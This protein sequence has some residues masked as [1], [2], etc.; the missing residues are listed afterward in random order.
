MVC[1]FSVLTH[2]PHEQ[3][4]LY[5]REARRV[6]EPGGA[7]VFS[8]LEFRIPDHW[9]LFEPRL[10]DAGGDPPLVM[11]LGRDGIEA[12]AGRLGLEVA[13]MIDGNV[14]H[15]PIP[16]PLT[17]DDGTTVA[18]TARLGPI[19]QSVCVLRKPAPWDNPAASSER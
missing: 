17:F 6:L 11:F 1:F 9:A 18:G 7:V 12:W 16:H 10:A 3:S 15:V 5:L 2:L 13:A 19:G 14:P 4:Y 8:F